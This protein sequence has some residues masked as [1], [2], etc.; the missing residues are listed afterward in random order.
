MKYLRQ[1][2]IMNLNLSTYGFKKAKEIAKLPAAS[3]AQLLVHGN[4]AARL[5]HNQS[6]LGKDRVRDASSELK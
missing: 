2:K 5:A 6:N 4:Q 3:Q 1:F